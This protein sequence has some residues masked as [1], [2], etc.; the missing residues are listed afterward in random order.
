MPKKHTFKAV[1]QNA[2]EASG[3]G[4]FVEIKNSKICQISE[5]CF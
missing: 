2:S 4:A 3:G 1:I 5:F